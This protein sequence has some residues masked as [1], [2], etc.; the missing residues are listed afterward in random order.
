MAHAF[1]PRQEPETHKIRG[2]KI[3]SFLMVLAPDAATFKRL[4]QELP[5]VRDHYYD[6]DLINDVVKDALVLPSYYGLLNSEWEK[7]DKVYGY[8]RGVDPPIVH[9][10]SA[11]KPWSFQASSFSNRDKWDAQF[12]DA[13]R[14][15]HELRIELE[16]T[17]K[18]PTPQ[19]A[20]GIP[21]IW[22]DRD[23]LLNVLLPSSLNQT[24]AP[25]EVV[26]VISGVPMGEE[27]RLREAARRACAPLPLTMVVSEQLRFAGWARNTVATNVDN[28]QWIAFVDSDDELHPRRI[29]I[30]SRF[31][32]RHTQLQLLLHSHSQSPKRIKTKDVVSGQR[33]LESAKRTAANMPLLPGTNTPNIH[34]GHP[35]VHVALLQRFR[36]N[37]HLRRGQD[38][39]FLHRVIQG[40]NDPNKYAMLNVPLTIHT[41]R[42]ARRPRAPDIPPEFT[43]AKRIGDDKIF[44]RTGDI[45]DMWIRDSTAQVWPYRDSHPELVA[46]VLRQQS[47]F[48]QHDVYANSYKDHHRAP[49]SL[50]KA[51]QALGRGGWVATRNYELDSGCYFLRLLHHAWKSTHLNVTDFRPTVE[52]LV[53]TWIVEQRHEDKSPYRYPELPHNGVG[54]PVGYT[55]MTWSGFR[56]SDDACMYGYHIPSNL[57]AATMLRHV[58]TM[59]PD[60]DGANRLRQDILDGVQQYGTWMDDN[61]VE[62]YCYEVDGLG[63]CMK[64]DDANLPSLLSIPYFDPDY[65][66]A[67]WN[68][69]YD[70]VWSDANPYFYSGKAAEGIGSPHTPTNHIWPLSLIA[71]GLV[72]PSVRDEM[73]D[74]VERTNVG[75]KAHE[76]FH[77]DDFTK[78]TREDFSWPNALFTELI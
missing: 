46:D 53:R 6:M 3:T 14:R 28:A 29:E 50:P 10:T 66:R 1:I 47:F 19:I 60:M 37:E 67:L 43:E 71:R 26:V 61:G 12:D 49:K 42:S 2:G 58:L 73:K 38:T 39:E 17:L 16:R 7:G 68:A 15:W 23:P 32:Q 27:A 44:V 35:V 33:L 48:I 65:D 78:Y 55:G 8:H 57:F 40:L 56:P 62:R 54:T 51:E 20:L 77:K 30:A 9:F 34:H 64:M 41:P 18:A 4:E 25:S 13:N 52:L 75:G 63:G 21:A 76:S 36:Y 5:T 11:G 22:D 24:T 74:M 72:D 31:I 69:T 45:L 59:F 70:W